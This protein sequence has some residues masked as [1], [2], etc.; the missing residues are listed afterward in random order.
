MLNKTF[1]RAVPP[2]YAVVT[3]CGG[4]A[5]LAAMR[6][7]QQDLTENLWYAYQKG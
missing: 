7:F 2:A 1:E 4:P 6:Q 5:Q 3:Q